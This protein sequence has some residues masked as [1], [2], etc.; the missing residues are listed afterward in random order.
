MH[1]VANHRL[2]HRHVDQRMRDR[3]PWRLIVEDHLRLLVERGALLHVR[4]RL[5]FVD[6]LGEVLVAPLGD[7]LAAFTRRAA[8]QQHAH[9]VVRIAVVA[10]PAQ[11]AHHVLAG[12]QALA[13]LAPFEGLELG[14]DADLRQVRLHQLG[15]LLGIRIVG[16]LHRHVP[17]VGLEVGDTGLGQHGLRLLRI[18]RIGLD[19]V[20]IGPDRRRDRVLRGLAGALIDRRQDR[21]LVDRHVDGLTHLHVVERRL[22]HVHREIADI[23]AFLLQHLELRIGLQLRDVSRVRIGDDIALARFQARLARRLVRRDGEHQT[24]DRLLAAEVIDVRVV[25]DAIVLVIAGPDEGA[26]SDRLLVDLLRRSGLHH[27]IHVFLGM[28]G[29]EVHAEIGDEGRFRLGQGELDRVGVDLV[30]RLQEVRHAHVVEVVVGAAGDLVVRIIRLPHAV[31]GGDHVVGVEVTA[32]REAAARMEPHALP[33]MERVGE[34]VIGDVPRFGQRRHDLGGAGL[35]FHQA[36][37]H[38]ISGI[39]TGA[40]GVDLR[41]E[42]LRA[43]LGAINQGLGIGGVREA[44]RDRGRCD[45]PQKSTFHCFSLPLEGRTALI[46]FGISRAA[47][48][49]T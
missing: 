21:V 42:I 29:G 47:L 38:R 39:E 6:Q 30:D 13:V 4:R 43:A 8:G 20:V 36:I 41:I 7:V 15:H 24:V 5:C 37:E 48:C 23:E 2:L 9:E 40:G 14:S 12:L 26:G 35:E 44:K 46:L 25:D 1:L 33:Q 31:E 10:R 28:D 11:H 34:A 45:G 17:E 18:V 3:H 32:R 49:E 19:R 27:R 22:L 16:T